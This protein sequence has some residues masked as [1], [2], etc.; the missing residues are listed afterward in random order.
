VTKS[1][2][3]ANNHSG[4]GPGGKMPPSTAGETPAATNQR[5]A[6]EPN[7]L[8]PDPH[9]P[10]AVAAGILPAVEPWRPARRT[11][12]QTFQSAVS[13]AF[14]PAGCRNVSGDSSA[15][16]AGP[17]GKS[18]IRQTG[19]SALPP[20]RARFGRSIADKP[21]IPGQSHPIR[22]TNQPRTRGAS[23]SAAA[24]TAPYG[25]LAVSNHA[26]STLRRQTTAGV[27]QT[28]QSA[29]SRVSQPADRPLPGRARLLNG[30]P[31]RKSAIRQVGKPAVRT[32]QMPNRCSALSRFHGPTLRPPRTSNHPVRRYGVAPNWRSPPC[33]RNTSPSGNWRTREKRSAKRRWGGDSG[34]PR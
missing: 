9:R 32:G 11:V 29:V 22:H 31:I 10:F 20:D 15:F 27:P 13:R 23:W 16:S 1:S 21:C 28:S 5:Q 24:L 19:M 18:A 8:F 7:R 14:Q 12:A 17:T 30:L 34:Q 2:P 3:A 26:R 6:T 4:A 33:S 25:H